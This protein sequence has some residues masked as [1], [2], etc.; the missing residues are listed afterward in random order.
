MK[1][2]V[3]TKKWSNLYINLSFGLCTVCAMVHFPTPPKPAGLES[4]IFRMRKSLA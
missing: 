2:E 4:Q 1:I 3:L